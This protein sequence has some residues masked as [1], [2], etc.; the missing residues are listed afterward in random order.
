VALPILAA[1]SASAATAPPWTIQAT[2]NPGLINQLSGVSCPSATRCA[3]AGVEI[4]SSRDV[5]LPELWNGTIWQDP[6]PVAGDPLLA[7][8][9]SVMDGVS[10]PTTTKCELVG[11]TG[12]NGTLPLAA[13][14]NGKLGKASI[15]SQLV[16]APPGS[17]LALLNGVSCTSVNACTAVGFF[18]DA[19]H[20]AH[21]LVERWNGSSWQID[22]SGTPPGLNNALFNAVSC[23]SATFCM[24]VGSHG[25]SAELVAI[26]NG[27][28]W[29]FLLESN[30]NGATFASLHGVSCAADGSCITVGQTSGPNGSTGTFP[31]ALKWIP[32]QFFLL[33]TVSLSSTFNTLNSVSCTSSSNCLAVGSFQ[34]FRGQQ[35]TLAEQW[36]GSTWSYEATPNPAGTI[37]NLLGVSCSSSAACTAV[38]AFRNGAGHFQTLA[39]RFVA[40]GSPHALSLTSR[41]TV[42]ALLRKPRSIELLVFTRG[43]HAHL[44]GSVAL[45]RHPRGLSRI[46][47]NLRVGGRKLR[48]GSYTAELV[49]VFGRGVTSDGPSVAFDLT[50]AGLVRVR[51]ATCSVTAAERG[52]C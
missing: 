10:C 49:A 15:S 14:W 41:G 7:S 51:S 19:A 17:T 43:R 42:L 22:P 48:A 50:R 28:T 38:G 26:W 18:T 44:L 13:L 12:N 3:A 37:P 16:P 11:V 4:T 32:N 52:R 8:R 29:Q 36:N 45:G 6:V 25:S 20:V 27:S 47:W 2:N 30:F 46:R 5:A 23:A 33:N 31:L 35:D 24:A 21:T 1:G 40:A 34:D 39:E 9:I